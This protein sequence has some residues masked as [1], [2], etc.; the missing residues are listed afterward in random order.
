ASSTGAAGA[1]SWRGKR[2]CRPR[3]TRAPRSR[4]SRRA[5]SGPASTSP[6]P[7]RSSRRSMERGAS[8]CGSGPGQSPAP[9]G[10]P[11]RRRPAAGEQILAVR[12]DG[13]KG[14]KLDPDV[15]GKRR[16]KLC[17]RLEALIAPEEE[18][19]RE[20]SPQELAL[21]LREQ[22]AANTI[23]GKQTRRQQQDPGPEL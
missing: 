4:R 1:R 12:P 14:S 18:P 15:T 22:L 8:C 21:A 20:R 9:R 7:R 13:L 10:R 5:R 6:P 2:R 23:A 19:P 11:P 3:R 16:E 17:A